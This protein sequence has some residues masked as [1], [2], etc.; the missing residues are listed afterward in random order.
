MGIISIANSKDSDNVLLS[1]LVLQYYKATYS[2]SSFHD[3]M[4]T[5]VPFLKSLLIPVENRSIRA[6]SCRGSSIIS[7]TF[8]TKLDTTIAGLVSRLGLGSMI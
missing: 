2:E 6:P 4:S 8:L 3:E 5:W 7:A 1:N